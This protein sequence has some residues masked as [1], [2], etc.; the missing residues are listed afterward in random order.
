M[1]Y[2][3]YSKIWIKVLKKLAEMLMHCKVR[4]HDDFLFFEGKKKSFLQGES[5]KPSSSIP[6][7]TS[8]AGICSLR[9]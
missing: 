6:L 3:F 9:T 1:Q 4:I 2:I 5:P 7:S 8:L